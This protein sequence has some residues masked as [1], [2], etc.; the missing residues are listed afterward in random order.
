MTNRL[1]IAGLGLMITVG[2]AGCQSRA[3]ES[4]PDAVPVV[5]VAKIRPAP[6]AQPPLTG[7]VVA[8]TQ[9]KVAFQAGG[10]IASREVERGQHVADGETL[11]RLDDHDLKL[12]LAA[13]KARLRQTSAEARFAQENFKR[14]RQLLQ[15]KVVGQQDFDQAQSAMHSAESARQAA[16]A[17]VDQARRALGYARL[18]A[19]FA[20]T[21]VEIDADQGDVVAAGQPVLTLAADGPRLALVD[22]PEQRLA[23]LPKQ[24]RAQLSGG[25]PDIT[26]TRY[27]VAGA[28]DPVTRTWAVRYRLAGSS[29][30]PLGRTV[31]L[32]FPDRQQRRTVP[33][34]A[35]SATDEHAFVFVIDQGK[36][37][38]HPVRVLKIDNERAV[39][40]TDL[41]VGTPVVA[42]GLN[43][44]HD[45][46][47]V[48]VQ[49]AS[50]TEG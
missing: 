5:R 8:R 1:A 28:A 14:I 41:A 20:G 37:R 27:S 3:A 18:T 9:S 21:V 42:V 50:E 15:R 48:R 31:T 34:G 19:P 39:I 36:V 11:Y 13:A 22:V 2:L 17:D 38:R 16:R 33:I 43:R 23:A 45:G 44:L 26:A 46:E 24:A 12:R 10:R 49:P 29:A 30:P 25:G 32:R 40:A 35:L 47:A 4:K 6:W 7:T